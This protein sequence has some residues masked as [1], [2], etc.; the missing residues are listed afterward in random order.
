MPK[1]LNDGSVI[2]AGDIAWV[3]LDPSLGAEQKK[4]RPCVVVEAGASPLPLAIILSITNATFKESK[5]F[6]PIASWKAIGLSK[7][8]AVDCYQIR[9]VSLQRLS[10]KM[11]SLD[12]ETMNEV[13]HRLAMFLDI[14]EQ[15]TV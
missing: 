6:V 8:S 2:E 10:R 11:G 14:D 5:T 4:T 12:E 1:T 13:K 15:H 3:C 9:A 7:P